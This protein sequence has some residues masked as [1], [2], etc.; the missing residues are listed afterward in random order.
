M[1]KGKNIEEIIL[2]S[3]FKALENKKSEEFLIRMINFLLVFNVIGYL[4]LA[5]FEAV[6]T[7]ML[8]LLILVMIMYYLK[9][10]IKLFLIRVKM[11][12]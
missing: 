10:K 3:E 1:E 8:P 7:S 12:K 11:R 6:A 9:P 5:L 2:S 4:Y